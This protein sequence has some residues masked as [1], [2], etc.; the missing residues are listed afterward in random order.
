MKIDSKSEYCVHYVH[1]VV[2]SEPVDSMAAMLMSHLDTCMDAT[3]L[4]FF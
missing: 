2:I 3:L 1:V 4:H